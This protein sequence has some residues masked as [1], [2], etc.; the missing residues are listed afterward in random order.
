MMIDKTKPIEFL[1]LQTW[2]V[3]VAMMLV[4]LDDWFGFYFITKH[5]LWDM[6]TKQ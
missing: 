5:L 6:L 4:K 3:L 1:A 2:M